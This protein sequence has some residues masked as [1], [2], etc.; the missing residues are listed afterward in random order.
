MNF[1]E[2]TT[3]EEVILGLGISLNEKNI[4]VTGGS[5]GIGA[6]AARVFALA[7]ANVWITGRDLSK[8]K[9]VA[10]SIASQ[11]ENPSNIKILE[12]D[13]SSLASVKQCAENFLSLGIP[14][15]IL[16]NNAG[17]MGIQERTETVD[18]LEMQ[19]GTNHF[20][21]FLL[22]L[23]LIEALKA[24]GQARVAMVS[25]GAH[26]RSPILFEDVH[27]T[28]SVHSYAPVRALNFVVVV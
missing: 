10:D 23:C 11:I 26:W 19:I 17:V 8:T 14:L 4:I 13:L 16:L 7:G 15:H 1:N 24:A 28:G 9:A 18:G 21:H 2:S 22:T 20:G 12:L 3:A 5:S 6:E 27:L 25:S